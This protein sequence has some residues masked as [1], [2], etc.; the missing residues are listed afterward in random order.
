MGC[1]KLAAQQAETVFKNEQKD[2]TE[3]EQGP[4]AWFVSTAQCL[5]LNVMFDNVNAKRI[6]PSLIQCIRPPERER[7][8]CQQ[9]KLKNIETALFDMLGK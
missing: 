4:S 9:E 8:K 3:N 6:P 7:E 2:S 5:T 1:K